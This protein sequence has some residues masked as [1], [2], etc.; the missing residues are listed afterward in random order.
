MTNTKRWYALYTRPKWEKKVAELLTKKGIISY[1]PIR[2]VTKQWADRKKI[3]LEPLF[4]S[5]VFV[6]I[7]ANEYIRTLETDGV[8][9][10]V[11]FLGKPGI[12]KNEEIDV[13]KQ[14]L[15]EYENVAVIKAVQ[16]N[17]KVRILNGPLT[18]LEGEVVEVKNKTVKVSLPTLGYHLVAEIEKTNIEILKAG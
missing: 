8:L 6:S 7:S 16:S 17:D 15:A 3:V 9:N 11:H 4:T 10:F 18:A 12:I 13:I 5:Y 14:F 1:C 2:K